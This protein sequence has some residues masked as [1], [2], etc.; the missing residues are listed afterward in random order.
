MSNITSRL[1]CNIKEGM[2]MCG[3][4][5]PRLYSKTRQESREEHTTLQSR[6][7]YEH[8]MDNAV[9]GMKDLYILHNFRVDKK[10]PGFYKYTTS[11]DFFLTT[12]Y[13]SYSSTALRW[14]TPTSREL[15]QYF[16]IFGRKTHA[17]CIA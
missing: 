1:G 4:C 15:V 5:I 13:L 12:Y 6:P 11:K 9:M 2:L 14:P 10:K 17:D 16:F 7:L 3:R 8:K